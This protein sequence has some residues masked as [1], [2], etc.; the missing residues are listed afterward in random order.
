MTPNT[1]AGLGL[2]LALPFILTNF[3]VSLQLEPTYSWLGSIPFLRNSPIF[4]LA[5]LLLFPIGAFIAARPLFD[6]T[7]QKKQKFLWLNIVVTVTLLVLFIPVFSALSVE[8]Y[9]C[10]I[11]QIPN[12]D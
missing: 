7:S 8:L 9:R 5:L 2:L 1:F 4:P 3:V 10:E 6:K 11:L 12:C